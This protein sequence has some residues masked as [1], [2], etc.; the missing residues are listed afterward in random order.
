M[1]NDSFPPGMQTLPLICLYYHLCAHYGL[2]GLY[3]DTMK[4]LTPWFCS[5]NHTNHV[6]WIFIYMQGMLILDDA[7][8]LQKD[9]VCHE[10]IS[11]QILLHND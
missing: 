4:N 2:V 11:I 8:E 10:Y 5:L 9:K 6:H 3:A 7:K 1:A